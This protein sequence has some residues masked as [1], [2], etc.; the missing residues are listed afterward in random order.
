MAKVK[1]DTWR[2]Q[3]RLPMPLAEWLQGKANAN[4]RSLNQELVEMV[5]RAKEE[6]TTSGPAPLEPGG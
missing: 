3:I 6:E 4:Y 5:R 1:V 2:G